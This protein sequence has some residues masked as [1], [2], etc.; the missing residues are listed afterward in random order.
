MSSSSSLEK[1]ASLVRELCKLPAETEWLEFKR[2]RVDH[3][4]IGEYI[5]ALSNSAAL[6]DRAH[7]YLVWG[8][9]D[10]THEVVG[11]TFDSSAAKIGNEELEN[12]LLR[13]LSPKINFSFSTVE[14]D[15]LRVVVLEVGRA[16]RHPVQFM[17]NEFIRIGS[18]KKKLKEF[19]EKERELWRIFDE[20]PFEAMIARKDVRE[21]EVVTLLDYP[22]Y[23]DLAGIP[24]PENR[25]QILERLAAES[26]IRRNGSGAWD[27][28]NLGAILFAKRLEDF[29]TL[30]RKAVRV[31]AYEGG[32]RIST[33]KEQVGARGYAAG[34]EGLIGYINALLPSN[35]VIG[36]AIRKDVPM[37]PDLAVRE[38]V[39]NALIHQDFALGGAGPMI[40]IFKDRMEVTNPGTPLI[41]VE[42]FLDTPPRS[43]NE[44]LASLMRRFG[45]CEE[46]GSGV[47]KVVS[48]T[49]A[50]QLPA[51]EFAIV[52][53][54]TRATLFAHKELAK[55][56]KIERVRACYLHACLRYVQREYMT[57]AT[58]RERFGITI[59]NSATASRLIKEAVDAGMLRPYDEAAP[60]KFMKYV[61]Y[62]A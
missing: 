6:C 9:D 48:L 47:D 53:D 14:L 58:L 45:I 10:A 55:M 60:R 15:G 56:D 31:I 18:L 40:E 38:L 1:L 27:I 43:R 37:Y 21:E 8:I 50:Y 13:L 24:L 7:G 44:G 20:T 17:H 46:R 41:N 57:N 36:K 32:N 35:E 51:P 30:R 4:Q 39:A 29:G 59:Q 3:E 34:F 11:T 23:F 33:L 26:L 42:R 25:A 5:S 28:S 2:N 22:A 49:E 61:P 19:P 54:H 12:W 16:Y 52:S 62:W